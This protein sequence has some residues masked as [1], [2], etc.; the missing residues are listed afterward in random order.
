MVRWWAL[1][2]F[3]ASTGISFLIT[4]VP[5]VIADDPGAG[6]AAMVVFFG[7]VFLLSGLAIYRTKLQ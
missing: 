7:A 4:A 3:L 5:R 6:G 2:I 1:S